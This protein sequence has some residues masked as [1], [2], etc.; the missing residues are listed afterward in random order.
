MA[1]QKLPSGPAAIEAGAVRADVWRE[2][3]DRAPVD[4]VP[5]PC[6]AVAFASIGASLDSGEPA[7]Q[8]MHTM[9]ARNL[10]VDP[11]HR[12]RPSR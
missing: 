5:A 1:A 12:G 4:V 9:L 2:L 3:G 8:L 6:A 11:S 7:G 10:I